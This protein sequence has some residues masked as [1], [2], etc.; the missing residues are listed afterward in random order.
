MTQR[1]RPA[2][3]PQAKSGLLPA[4]AN[5]ERRDHIRND[6]RARVAHSAARLIAEGLTDYQ[7]AKQKAARQHGVA[8]YHALPDDLEIELALR[9]HLRM[10]ACETRPHILSALRDVALRLMLQLEPLSP[11]LVGAVLNGTANEFSEIE[12]ELVGVEPKIF[13]IYL[14][15]AGVEFDLCDTL[16]RKSGSPIRMPPV[17]KYHLEF[18]GTPVSIVLYEH[19]AARQAAHP[20]DSIRHDRAQRAGAEGLFREESGKS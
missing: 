6:L 7:A 4:P 14:L 19:H 5:F 2:V 10:F 16:Q 9:E 13:E 8:D 17:I 12:L 15:N 18:D 3:K 20:R 1:N 11:W